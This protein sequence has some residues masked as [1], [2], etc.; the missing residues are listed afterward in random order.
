L[1]ENRAF[2]REGPIWCITEKKTKKMYMY[3]FNDIIVFADVNEAT[4]EKYY[5][6]TFIL[7][8]AE[9]KEIKD[10]QSNF[11]LSLSLLKCSGTSSWFGS[12]LVRENVTHLYSFDSQTYVLVF[13]CPIR[14]KNSR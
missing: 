8:G 13:C 1:K 2:V 5:E 10:D 3:L 9:I 4:E 7:L 6:S 14:T 11:S 12:R